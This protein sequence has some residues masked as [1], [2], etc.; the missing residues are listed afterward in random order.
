MTF[1]EELERRGAREFQIVALSSDE[2][3]AMSAI[4]EAE[5]RGANEVIPYAL[6][7]FD[8]PTWTPRGEKPRRM[9]NIAVDRQCAA[10]AGDRF[11]LVGVPDPQILYTEN[12]APCAKCNSDCD[13]SFYRVDGS[14]FVSLPL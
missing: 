9:T 2:D 4:A 13:T 1:R 11:V 6:T 10:C 12:Y 14:R 7:L 3:R 8:D 5:R